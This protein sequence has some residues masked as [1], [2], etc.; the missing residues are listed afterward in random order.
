[1]GSTIVVEQGGAKYQIRDRSGDFLGQEPGEDETP[2]VVFPDPP[3]GKDDVIVREDGGIELIRYQKRAPSGR[4]IS[5][6]PEEEAEAIRRAITEQL[7][8]KMTRWME[9]EK[10]A[11]GAIGNAIGFALGGFLIGMILKDRGQGRRR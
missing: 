4:T 9:I 6:T 11:I 10:A 2:E 3:S 8:Y 7:V 1:L 5:I